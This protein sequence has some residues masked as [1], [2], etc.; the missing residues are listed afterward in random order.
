MRHC[1]TLA[2]IFAVHD[3]QPEQLNNMGFKYV[4][5]F[6]SIIQTVFASDTVDLSGIVL[7]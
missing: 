5:G 1:L 3:H 2:P 7:Q 6:N 4:L